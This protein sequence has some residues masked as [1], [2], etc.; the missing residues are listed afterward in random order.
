MF[1]TLHFRVG[2][3]CSPATKDAFPN[4]P[5][6]ASVPSAEGGSE[7]FQ[8]LAKDLELSPTPQPRPETRDTDTR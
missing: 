6:N 1:N 4:T 8:I 2:M 3:E 5:E 7:T